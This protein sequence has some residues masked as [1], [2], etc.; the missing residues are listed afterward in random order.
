MINIMASFKYIVLL[1]ILIFIIEDGVQ[2]IRPNLI[3]ENQKHIWPWRNH[4]PFPY[5]QPPTISSIPISSTKP[6]YSFRHPNHSIIFPIQ[7]P[8]FPQLQP[9]TDSPTNAQ[10]IASNPASAPAYNGA[11]TIPSIN[12][13]MVMGLPLCEHC[14]LK[15]HEYYDCSCICYGGF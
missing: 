13:P 10:I 5:T 3:S 7:A 2:A 11:P 12:C 8:M 14:E 4:N 9:S 6:P 15:N 1:L